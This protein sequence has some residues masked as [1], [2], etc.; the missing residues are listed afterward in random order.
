[1]PIAPDAT[2]FPENAPPAEHGSRASTLR[3][4]GGD[5]ARRLPPPVVIFCKSHS[6]SRLLAAAV[7][8]MGVFLGAERN[9]SFDALPMV[10]VVEHVV[11]RH[12]PDFGDWWRPSV[13]GDRTLHTLVR[14]AITRH[15]GGAGPTHGPWGWKLCE[16][17]YAVP[18]IDAVF[19]QARYIHLVRD[20][21]DV[22]F[23]D[24]AVPD[25]PF[26]KKVYFGTDRLMT[27]R[28]LRL[29]FKDYH[30]HSHL[31]NAAHWCASVS[32]GRSYGAMLGPRHLEVRYESLCRDFRGELGRVAAFLGLEDRD[33]TVAAL[34]RTVSTR[35]IGKHRDRP[36][37]HVREVLEIEAPLL[38]SLGY[39]EIDPLTKP[40]RSLRRRLAAWWPP[41]PRQAAA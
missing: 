6:G 10:P 25:T 11:A 20:G 41:E 33:D 36:A 19:P 1:M 39:L 23:C 32:L 29:G 14:Q 16:T 40:P 7:E 15:F 3:M 4:P 17:V 35:S 8:R 37:R 28:G 9:E 30:R 31:F 2:P 22:A 26:W 18:V 24:H 27:W 34:E 21:R 13:H 12:H 38:L 5:A